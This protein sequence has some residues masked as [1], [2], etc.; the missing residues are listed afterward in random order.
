MKK[1]IFSIITLTICHSLFSQ[2]NFSTYQAPEYESF[3]PNAPKRSQN[4]QQIRANGFLKNAY[5]DNYTKV[6]LMLTVYNPGETNEKV[7]LTK[8]RISGTNNSWSNVDSSV[9]PCNNDCNSTYY[10][11]TSMGYIYF[12]L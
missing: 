10:A 2:S 4:S 9:Y 11:R 12:D 3:V 1:I 5:S 8:Y 7:K 6:S